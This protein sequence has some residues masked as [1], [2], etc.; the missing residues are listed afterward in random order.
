MDRG[1]AALFGAIVAVGLGP[2]MWLGVRLGTVETAPVRPLPAVVGEH[3]SGPEQLLG[4]TGAGDSP[5]ADEPTIKATQRAK[6]EPVTASSTSPSATTTSPTPTA[7]PTPSE[8]PTPTESTP[9]TPPTESTT[10]PSTPP[11]DHTTTP[12]LPPDPPTETGPGTSG[13][14]DADGVAPYGGT[15]GIGAGGPG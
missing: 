5:L 6:L 8:S 7:S 13:P 14:S 4:G 10:T 9:S 11:T 3:N 15:G 12:T 2:A 1:P